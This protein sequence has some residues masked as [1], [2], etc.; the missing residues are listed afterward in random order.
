[1]KLSGNP[2]RGQV[3]IIGWG[4]RPTKGFANKAGLE[5]SGIRKGDNRID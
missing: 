4:R 2:G 5:I 1:M 3:L